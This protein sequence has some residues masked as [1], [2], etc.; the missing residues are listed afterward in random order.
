M[1]QQANKNNGKGKE[2]A[3]SLSGVV[4][5]VGQSQLPQEFITVGK[6][7]EEALGRAVIRDDKQRS[8]IIFLKARYDRHPKMGLPRLAN[9]TSWLNSGPAVGGFNRSLAAMTYTGIYVPEGAGIKFSKDN[10]K[11]LMELQ[12][13]RAKGNGQPQGDSNQNQGK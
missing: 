8:A 6:D 9:L 11:A 7:F 10:Q 5:L 2:R 12:K 13:E 1:V 4:K 3:G